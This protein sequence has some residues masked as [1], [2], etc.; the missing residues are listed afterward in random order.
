MM[1]YFALKQS[2]IVTHA[3]TWLNSDNILLSDISQSLQKDEYC[4]IL[5]T[6]VLFIETD[7]KMPARGWQE[8]GK[9]L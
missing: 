1:E 3:T 8:G 2:K 6:R 7:R 4:L 5:L 9:R